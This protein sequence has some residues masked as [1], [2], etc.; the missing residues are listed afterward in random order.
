LAQRWGAGKTL[1][2]RSHCNS[3]SAALYPA[4]LIPILS[5][6][7]LRGKCRRCSAVIESRQLGI[8]VAASAIGGAALWIAPNAV[9]LNGALFGWC[10]LT[11]AILDVDHFWLPDRLTALLAAS[12]LLLGSA[13]GQDRIIGALAGFG[14]L[15]LVRLLYRALRH[16][17][18]MGGG[19]P[20][21]LGGIGAWL[22]WQMLPLVVL[23]ASSTGLILVL[24]DRMRGRPLSATRQLPFGALMAGAAFALWLMNAA[25]QL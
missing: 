10:L 12:G 3:C 5:F 24:L 2:G 11:L 4:D 22:G 13:S 16:R 8:E 7:A 6:L 20:K 23:G 21:M 18:G 17:D 1:N 15:T 19:D 9:G 25:G 14:S